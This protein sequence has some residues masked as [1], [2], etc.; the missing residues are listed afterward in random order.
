MGKISCGPLKTMIFLVLPLIGVL[1]YYVY[2][3][4]IRNKSVSGTLYHKFHLLNKK[5]NVFVRN[6]I[7]LPENI[8]PQ[9]KFIE[10]EH[11]WPYILSSV[12]LPDYP[13]QAHP[14]ADCQDIICSPCMQPLYS[15]LLLYIQ[16]IFH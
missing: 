15:W 10:E 11:F 3:A 14:V 5:F 16:Y 4:L 1:Y 13:L 12:P 2:V 8:L 6:T 9:T 7:F